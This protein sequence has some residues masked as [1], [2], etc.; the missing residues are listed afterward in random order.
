MSLLIFKHMQVDLSYLA[1]NNI[2][3]F[4][5]DTRHLVFPRESWRSGERCR[6]VIREK[7]WPPLKR[8]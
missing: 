2:V 1:E 6:I 7:V 5:T 3:K 8:L 4:D